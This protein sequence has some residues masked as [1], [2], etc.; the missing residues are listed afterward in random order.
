MSDTFT[1]SIE[2]LDQFV[3]TVGKVPSLREFV[4]DVRAAVNDV[5]ATLE[6]RLSELYFTPGRL[7]D[8]R[9]G[10]SVNPDASGNAFLQFSLSYADKAVPLA[11]YPFEQT[12]AFDSGSKA[13]LRRGGK[14]ALTPVHWKRG[15][16]SKK[17]F[18]KVRKGKPAQGAR[19]GGNASKLAG[20]FTGTN[21]KARE[22]KETWLQWPTVGVSTG[23]ENRAPYSTLFGPTFAR[24]AVKVADTDTQVNKAISNVGDVILT[25]FSRYYENV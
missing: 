20:F 24:L 5:H 12:A 8:V 17:L 10:N 23:D 13:P 19:R 21:I 11:R 4:P 1:I 9:V 22:Q 25:G 16:W 2:G 3:T 15:A 18:V 14:F 7:T 6:R